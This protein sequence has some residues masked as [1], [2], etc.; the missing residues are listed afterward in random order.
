M[1]GLMWDGEG[2]GGQPWHGA[3]GWWLDGQAEERTGQ[4]V[5]CGAQW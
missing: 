4:R 2:L 5:P 1:P 3:L